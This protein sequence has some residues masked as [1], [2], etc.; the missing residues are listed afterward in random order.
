MWCCWVTRRSCDGHWP[1][2]VE[3]AVAEHRKEHVGSSSGEAEKGLGVVLALL[4]LLVVVGAGGGV[5]QGRRTRRGR[6]PV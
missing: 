6:T 5:G 3:G 4:D 2:L 1:R